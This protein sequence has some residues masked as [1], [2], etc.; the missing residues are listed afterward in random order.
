MAGCRTNCIEKPLCIGF[1]RMGHFIGSHPLW[2]LII[3][4]FI[5]AGLGSGFYFLY[6][7]M[8]NDIE[9]QFTPVNGQAKVERKYIQETFPGNDSIFSRLRLS[10]DGNYATLIASSNGNILSKESLQY[11][12]DL[13]LKVRTMD[14]HLDDQSFKY[15]HVCA[16]VMGSCISNEILDIIEYNASNIDKVELT[17]PWYY[18]NF[19]ILSLHTSL[20][21][22][23]LYEG[24]SVVKSA[25]AIQLYYYLHD[26]DKRKTDLWLKSFLNLVSDASSASIQVSRISDLRNKL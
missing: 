19:S 22:V 9:E 6:D 5:S 3:P 21:G 2:F 12:L 24:G 13:D 17:F 4:L 7:R 11:I 23:T 10:T 15:T 18:S 1:K 16:V 20:G 14:V 8:S 26:D 25:K